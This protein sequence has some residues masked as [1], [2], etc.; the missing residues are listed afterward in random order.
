ML[1]FGAVEK[2]ATNSTHF[3]SHSREKKA[4]RR[5][6]GKKGAILCAFPSEIEKGGKEIYY[7]LAHS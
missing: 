4:A 6:P 3:V 1:P 5:S 2:A 7:E